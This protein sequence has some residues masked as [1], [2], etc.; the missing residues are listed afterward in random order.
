LPK[1]EKLLAATDLKQAL[2]STFAFP[3]L[4]THFYLKLPEVSKLQKELIYDKDKGLLLD[5]QTLQ[6][7]T[8]LDHRGGVTKYRIFIANGV[9]PA[10]R[11]AW[12][13]ATEQDPGNLHIGFRDLNRLNLCFSNLFLTEKKQKAFYSRS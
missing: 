8:K 5:K 10:E 11:I 7:A 3:T 1:A 2:S 6:P 4:T 9:F 12:K 13:L